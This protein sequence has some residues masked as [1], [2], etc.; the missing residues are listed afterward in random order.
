MA[1]HSQSS[2]SGACSFNLW[3]WALP[4]WG[5]KGQGK[6][7]PASLIMVVSNLRSGIKLLEG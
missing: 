5:E 7:T 4:Q 1:R 3:L 2:L 6:Q